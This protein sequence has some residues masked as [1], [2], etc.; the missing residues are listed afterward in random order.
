MSEPFEITVA[1]RQTK[2]ERQVSA[3]STI[4]SGFTMGDVIGTLQMFPE[5]RGLWP[6]SSV[7]ES[8]NL[9]DISGEGRTLTNNGTTLRSLLNNIVPYA[10]LNGS[11]QYFSRADEAGLRITGSLS[12]G[13]WYYFTSLAKSM[14]AM[15][16]W[17]A[18]GN[19][20]SYLL[21]ALST[22]AVSSSVSTNGTGGT[23]VFTSSGT[24]GEIVTGGWYFMAS[25]FT[26]S[27]E[28]ATFVNKT[29]H[30]NTTSV[31]A[32]I[33]VSTAGLLLGGVSAAAALNGRSAMSFLCA[34]LV[35]DSL[36]ARFFEV[37]R[38]FFGV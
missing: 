22:G 32:S 9:R 15:S 2:T 16:K 4:E 13:G 14:T 38:G 7:D 27:T 37:S 20:R 18:A 26:P 19:Q 23:A 8:G 12:L 21:Q 28:L 11:T 30:V 33:F 35:P 31:P 3:L 17:T 34:G 29:K 36:L 5:L 24:A 25:R 10:T 6:Y 1:R